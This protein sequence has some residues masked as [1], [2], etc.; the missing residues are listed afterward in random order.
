MAEALGTSIANVSNRIKRLFSKVNRCDDDCS[1]S[2]KSRNGDLFFSKDSIKYIKIEGTDQPVKFY[3]FA[4]FN[5]LAHFIST[6]KALLVVVYIQQAY[7][8]KFNSQKE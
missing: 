1:F 7:N 6:K 4:V 5:Y 3:P 8:D 2:T